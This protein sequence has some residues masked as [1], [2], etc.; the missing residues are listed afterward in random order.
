MR[1]RWMGVLA[2][3]VAAATSTAWAVD[4]PVARPLPTAI[5]TAELL[6]RFQDSF[7]ASRLASL[8]GFRAHRTLR[9]DALT[10]VVRTRSVDAAQRLERRLSGQ[11]GVVW[12][13]NNALLPWR[14]DFAPNDPYYAPN[15]PTA[16]Q[17]GQWSLNDT[18]TANLDV[19]A[20]A[21]WAIATG[22]GV[23]IGIVDDGFETAHPDLSANYSSANSFN[24]GSNT[25]NPNP[26]T[27]EDNH[28]TALAGIIAA[29]GG[30]NTGITGM[31]PLARWAGI[32]VNFAGL[33][34]AQLV[35][36]IRVNSLGTSPSIKIKSHSYGPLA[37][38]EAPDAQVAELEATTG[39]IHVRSAG[40]LR[41]TLAEDVNKA[42]VR[43]SV[44][45]ITVAAIDS[46]GRFADYSSF[47]ASVAVTAPSAGLTS[48]LRA[49]L[50]TDRVSGDAGFN[51]NGT[52]DFDPLSDGAYTSLFGNDDQGGTSVA[53]GLVSGALALAAQVN[54]NLETRMAKHLLARTS[55]QIDATDSSTTGDAWRTNNAGFRFNQNYGF[56]LLQA[57]ALVQ[58]AGQWFGA[59]PLAQESI[60]PIT[61]N[62][63]ITDN[64][65]T[66]ISRTFN[67]NTSAPMEELVV[68]LNITHAFQ[69]DLEAFVTSPRGTRSRL[70]SNNFGDDGDG[71]N[72]TFTSLAFWG[73]N[74][75]GTWTV[76][77]RD[78]FTGDVGT[79]VSLGATVRTGTLYRRIAGA[80]SF[81]DISAT[82]AVPVVIQLRDANT[83]AL[84]ASQ[85]VS[86]QSGQP[87]AFDGSFSGPVR[88]QVSSLNWL[89]RVGSATVTSGLTDLGTLTLINGDPNQDL[90]VDGNDVNVVL[91]NFGNEGDPGL[92]G[93]VNWDG[94]VDGNDVNVILANFGAEGD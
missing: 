2:A 11:P 21:A 40:N 32:R 68:Q 43:N 82:T 69:G 5:P 30:N 73:E 72:W 14:Q 65:I 79:W 6:V 17:P 15:F 77:V 25:T 33:T 8:E 78:R 39:T 38:F 31:A 28:G 81:S 7:A 91:S 62:T 3:G 4:R 74:P 70:F 63:S 50:T 12:T 66:G 88:V 29:R 9:T 83:N 92:T 48:G 19:E 46:R 64:N 51:R 71:F 37:P 20:P 90:I 13:S 10:W 55:R 27:V 80:L 23:V 84:L 26:L 24:F 61:V 56:G 34:T 53:A 60:T 94:I 89:N 85:N 44:A 52:T 75:N 35:D 47:G 22:T 93:D 86:L 76:Q 1:Q 67:I 59:T 18:T 87:F 58:Q 45:S 49:I 54:P 42:R 57:D 16:G 41:G 36:A